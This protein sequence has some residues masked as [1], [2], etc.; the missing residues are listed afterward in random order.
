M[1]LGDGT[2]TFYINGEVQASNK[3]SRSLTQTKD[4]IW[5]GGNSNHGRDWEGL[6]DEVRLSKSRRSAEWIKLCYENQ[7]EQQTLVAPIKVPGRKKRFGAV[8]PAVVG[9]ECSRLVVRGNAVGADE[10]YWVSVGDDGKETFLDSGLNVVRAIP[11]LIDETS[12]HWRLKA[13]YGATWETSDVSVVLKDIVPDPQFKLV[14]S[15]GAGKAWDG[16][17]DIEIAP[18]IAN[19]SDIAAAGPPN[20]V[21]HY[22]WVSSG[23]PVYKVFTDSGVVIKHAYKP[24]DVSVTLNLDNSGA[25]ASSTVGPIKIDL[26]PAP[27]TPRPKLTKGKLK[28]FVL[29]GQSNMEGHGKVD[30]VKT[31]G[32]IPW[33]LNNPKYAADYKHLVDKDGKTLVYDDVWVYYPRESYTYE[34]KD[35]QYGPL[36]PR[37]GQSNRTKE[38]R[39]IGPE[40]GI[41]LQMRQQF[42]EQ[43]LLIK[44]CWGGHS[45][46][47][48]FLPP[49]VNNKPGRSYTRMLDIVQH[50]TGNL[51]KYFPKYD[52][53]GFEIAGVFWHQGYND[54]FAAEFK[55]NYEGNLAILIDDLRREWGIPNLPFV[56]GESGMMT[57]EIPAA[58]KAVAAIQRF[59]GNVE[60]VPT[61]QFF[62]QE[63]GS[64]AGYHWHYSF[65]SHYN[66][67][68]SMG[69]AMKKLLAQ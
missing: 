6:I 25:L 22:D 32:S 24:G 2:A 49:G 42:D 59:K 1:T 29:V 30:G 38:N 20:N 44:T 48:L 21:I 41:G 52:G 9:R 51:K 3:T 50:V 58:Q 69:Q 27:V 57:G 18:K 39:L 66:V 46:G 28:V 40:F 33:L 11:R 61:K 19:K 17:E 12:M 35:V 68:M 31:E 47:A 13:R 65:Y 26:N 60:F 53:K 64:G 45:L 14:S 7:K 34:P 36:E 16:Q 15:L 63:L 54:Q 43:V 67:G 4:P 5:I 62:K 56:I 8:K 55:N 10:F 37:F 23:Q